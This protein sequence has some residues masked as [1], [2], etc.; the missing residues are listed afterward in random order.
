MIVS[1]LPHKL[2]KIAFSSTLFSVDRVKC[3][4]IRSDD[5][6]I[7]LGTRKNDGW[8]FGEWMSVVIVGGWLI[9][10]CLR[11][12]PFF[13]EWHKHITSCTTMITINCTTFIALWKSYSYRSL[14]SE[15]DTLKEC[16]YLIGTT[17]KAALIRTRKKSLARS[18][19]VDS[20][21]TYASRQQF[22]L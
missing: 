5:D 22:S 12:R 21:R 14:W 7:T 13:L 2:W 15:W 11:N 8:L 3:V 18:L 10:H 16:K 4:N 19:F 9:T 6:V 17:H 1:Q 20:Q